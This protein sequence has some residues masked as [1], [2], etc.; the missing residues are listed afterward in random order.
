MKG[1]LRFLS[2]AVLYLLLIA[3]GAWLVHASMFDETWQR[4]VIWMSANRLPALSALWAGWWVVILFALAGCRQASRES[5]VSLVTETGT[6]S[7]STRALADYLL[8]LRGE[9]SALLELKPVVD[10]RGAEITVELNVKIRAGTQIP[11]LCRLLQ[12]RVRQQIHGELGLTEPRDVRVHVKEIVVPATE[13][14]SGAISA[15][16]GGWAGGARM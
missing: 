9:F 7:V 13:T 1:L 12:E 15:D 2:G 6:V 14:Q 5:V 3:G 4:S 11:E 16:S 8:R 10:A